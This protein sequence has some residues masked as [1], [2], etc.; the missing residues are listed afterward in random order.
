MSKALPYPY[1]SL[2]AGS[3]P[4]SRS[5]PA[6][7]LSWL[8]SADTDQCHLVVLAGSEI[9]DAGCEPIEVLELACH[10]MD[11]LFGLDLSGLVG[12]LAVITPGTVVHVDPQGGELPGEVTAIATVYASGESSLHVYGKGQAHLLAANAYGLVPDSMRRTLGQST[13]ESGLNPALYWAHCW[14]EEIRLDGLSASPELLE[15][16]DV[17]CAHPAIEPC[18]L[19]DHTWVGLQD[20]CRSRQ[21]EH[22]WLTGWTGI[23]QMLANP[24]LPPIDDEAAELMVAARW[25][26]DGSFSRWLVNQQPSL[27][28]VLESVAVFLSDEAHQLV[29][30]VINDALVIE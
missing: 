2:P 8:A 19:D 7:L 10:P 16:D 26:D 11:W 14:L 27:Y 29:R 15:L 17:I 9:S 12:G 24:E 5:L 22:S 13:S 18:E 28:E 6:P 3:V 21:A 23:R 30:S 25:Y 20:F 1:T 4:S